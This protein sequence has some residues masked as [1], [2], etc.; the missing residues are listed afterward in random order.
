MKKLGARFFLL[1]MMLTLFLVPSFAF[2]AES[3]SAT[4]S[5]NSQTQSIRVNEQVNV[6]V[7]ATKSE[8]LYGAEFYVEYD[9]K[10]L[11]F[12]EVVNGSH[13][14]TFLSKESTGLGKVYVSAIKKGN[15][16]LSLSEVAILK[17]KADKVN[18]QTKVKLTAVKGITN[19][20]ELVERDGQ[21][22]PTMKSHAVNS[23]DELTLTVIG[24]GN[25]EVDVADDKDDE[26]IDNENSN[27]NQPPQLTVVGGGINSNYILY[28]PV[29]LTSI[30][31]QQS[32]I[33]RPQYSYDISVIEDSNI[34]VKFP[35]LDSEDSELV[36]LYYLNDEGQ[37]E[38]VKNVKREGSEL[39]ATLTQS[40]TY[41]VMQ[42][43][44]NYDD[45]SHLYDEAKRAINLLS[46]QQIVNGVSEQSF[47]PNK[48]ITRSEWMVMLVRAMGWTS[49][50]S[51][52]LT[53]TDVSP[54]AWY[55]EALKIAS[56]KGL[57]S[58]YEDGAFRG[59][60][61][62]SRTELT[63]LISRVLTLLNKTQTVT[64][65]EPFTDMEDV[66]NYA[67]Q[68]VQLMRDLGFM[69]GYEDG[70]FLPTKSTTRVEAAI[71][72]LRLLEN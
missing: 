52:T 69:K 63:V 22:Y 44:A 24:S 30:V 11:S 60:N 51:E 6:T 70:S 46:M 17:F 25:G 9:P 61:P 64:P 38:Y 62:V 42:F 1:G 7:T 32:A 66:P 14:T 50:G 16:S 10:I 55:A 33:L 68:A 48:P 13:Y 2:A 67:K 28:A 58:G 49:E 26:N 4:L 5:L 15:Q 36:A 19:E 59:N 8:L 27:G 37:W 29:T 47:A 56:S 23:G 18:G 20:R 31:S 40:G 12:V 43:E 21:F 53:F 39:I 72:L 41:A 34:E 54:D 35:I 65:S 57:V 45:T 3:D 71:M